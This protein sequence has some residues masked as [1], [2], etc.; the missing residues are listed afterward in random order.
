MPLER[1]DPASLSLSSC[2]AND[3]TPRMP[4]CCGASFWDMLPSQGGPPGTP[5]LLNM[6]LAA[7]LP[8][9]QFSKASA[10][11]KEHPHNPTRRNTNA[12]HEGAIWR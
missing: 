11:L 7:C 8:H 2:T 1:T 4:C 5:G 9:Q 10:V 12:G 6:A 3:R